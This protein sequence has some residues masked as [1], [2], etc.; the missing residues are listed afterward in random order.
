[1]FSGFSLKQNWGLHLLALIIA[2]I[3]VGF[4]SLYVPERPNKANVVLECKS[5]E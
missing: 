2:I 4:K 3:L 1:M 5:D